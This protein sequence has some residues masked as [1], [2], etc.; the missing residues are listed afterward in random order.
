MNFFL[1]Q[2]YIARSSKKHV[3]LLALMTLK[4]RIGAFIGKYGGFKK[5][6]NV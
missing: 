5:E 4:T 2:E 3:N 6:E 1:E